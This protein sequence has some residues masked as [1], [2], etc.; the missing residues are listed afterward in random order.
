LLAPTTTAPATAAAPAT[1]SF[2]ERRA[3]RTTEPET[4]IN[5]SPP[6]A[7]REVVGAP[8]V[9]TKMMV[10]A[11]MATTMMIMRSRLLASSTRA[12]IAS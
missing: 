1:A 12:E 11:T 2:L 4:P 5:A 10:T 8:D 9:L 6:M 7:K 3:W